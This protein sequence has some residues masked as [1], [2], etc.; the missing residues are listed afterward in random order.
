MDPNDNPNPDD[1]SLPADG[2]DPAAPPAGGEP[3]EPPAPEPSEVELVDQA[4]AAANEEIEP[5]QVAAEGD[6]DKAKGGDGKPK[7]QPEKDAAAAA[8]K[9]KPEPDTEIAAESKALGLKDGSKANERF[10]SM[11]TEIKTLAPFKAELEKAGIKD[12]TEIPAMIQ[13]AQAADDMVAL[14]M[15]TGA[16]PDQ[17]GKTLDYLAVVNKAAAGDAKAADAAWEMWL[18]EGRELA[19]AL[20]R[21]MPG[22]HDPL[23]D[24]PDLQAEIDGGM[25]RERALEIA[26]A[27][28]QASLRAQVQEHAARSD[29]QTRQQ[30]EVIAKG[31][32]SLRAWEADKLT[33]PAYL[34]LRDQ[35]S[36]EVAGIK[37]NLPPAQWTYATD[38]AYR[39]IAAQARAAAP[40]EPERKPPPGPMRS[41]GVGQRYVQQDFAT[42]EDA[43]NAALDTM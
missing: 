39:A 1:L 27:R 38:L 24:H 23:A 36:A 22:I 37:Q 33:D 40:R 43:V 9:A 14:V 18:S 21:D 19:K 3:V 31:V 30:Q 8:D 7:G 13:R 42:A 6:D 11:A 16:T 2:G 29:Q 28:R 4:L 35:L 5:D 25:A 32:E 41:G 34:A 10:V 15:D 17:Y 12:P 20:G 26:E